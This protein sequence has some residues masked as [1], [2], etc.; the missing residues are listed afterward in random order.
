MEVKETVIDELK[1]RIALKFGKE[2]EESYQIQD[3]RQAIMEATNQLLGVTT[4]KRIYKFVGLDRVI[5][6]RVDTLDILA[7]YVGYHNFNSFARELGENPE[8]SAFGQIMS[9]AACDVEVGEQIRL[10]YKPN[11]KL[12]LTCIGNN[13]FVVNEALNSKL[14]QC[15]VLTINSSFIIGGELVVD[16]VKRNG[17]HLG[18]YCA[19]KDGGLTELDL[20]AL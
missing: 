17:K 8:I 12:L 14:M 4:L 7:Q 10:A 9:I 11:R 2:I 5:V 16:D 6:P 19:A 18:S 1:R 3:L 13:E 15:D 20:E